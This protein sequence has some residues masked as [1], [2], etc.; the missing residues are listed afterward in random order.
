M[1]FC[2]TLTASRFDLLVV[3]QLGRFLV[4]EQL[5]RLA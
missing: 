2:S 5:Q 4:G 1:P 3:D